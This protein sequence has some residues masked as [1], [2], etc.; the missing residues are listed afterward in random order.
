MALNFIFVN[1]TL[2]IKL[3]Y[4]I[5]DSLRN[6]QKDIVT[7][8]SKDSSGI[9]FYEELFGEKNTDFVAG[10]NTLNG[11]THLRDIFETLTGSLKN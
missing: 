2:V 7:A 1:S 9:E 4:L 5:N 11:E 8:D 10:N 6:E 3:D